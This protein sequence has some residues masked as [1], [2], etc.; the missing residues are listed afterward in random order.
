MQA[1]KVRQVSNT[2]ESKNLGI[3]PTSTTAFLG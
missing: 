1:I 2:Q 3:Q